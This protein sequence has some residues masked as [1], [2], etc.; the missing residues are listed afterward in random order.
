M[1]LA[2]RFHRAARGEFLEA[3]ARYEAQRPG[4]GAEFISEV[5]RCVGLAAEQPQ[6][7]AIV[8]KN[9]RRVT[10][11]RFPYSIYFRAE[12]RRMVV[13]GVFHGSR[14]PAIWQGRA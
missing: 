11:R 8:R 9:T 2:V 3:A 14:D 13:L 7:Y 10:A 4:L 12:S 1:T 5:E 6:L